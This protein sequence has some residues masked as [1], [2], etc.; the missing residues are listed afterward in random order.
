MKI[1]VAYDGSD[2][3]K[4]ALNVAHNYAKKPAHNRAGR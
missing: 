2:A 4:V 1:L 3:G